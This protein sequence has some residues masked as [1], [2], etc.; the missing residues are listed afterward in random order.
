MSELTGQDL[1]CIRGE[2]PVFARL[3]F[4]WTA[5]TACQLTGPNGAG[6][7]SLLRVL[8]GLIQPAAGSLS[9]HGTPIDEDREAHRAR[10]SYC[11]HQEALKSALTVREGLQF[12][13]DLGGLPN[14]VDAALEGFE[15]TGLADTPARILSSGQKRRVAL[16]RL[17]VESRPI[18]LLDEPT[19]GLDKASQERLE[20]L[21]AAHRAEGGIV[22]A[23][24]H[25]PIALPDAKNLDMADFA[26]GRL[27]GQAA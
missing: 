7:S 12:W 1:T 10:V 16:A 18:W 9:W 3:N 14:R 20:H 17:I 6:K 27:R 25:V 11:G 21:I 24:T 8:A 2:R 5:G 26:P 23:A 4:A 22:A 13:A 15:L 19:V